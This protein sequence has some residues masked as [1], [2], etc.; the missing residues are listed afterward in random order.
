MSGKASGL[1]TWRESES[2]ELT[3]RAS[4]SGCLGIA[5]DY[6]IDLSQFAAASAVCWPNS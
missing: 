4:F 3:A 5:H 2:E 6:R 1:V